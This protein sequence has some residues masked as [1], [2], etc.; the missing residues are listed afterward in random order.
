MP[1]PKPSN[2][3]TAKIVGIIVAVV[4]AGWLGWQ[5]WAIAQNAEA[6]KKMPPAWFREDVDELKDNQKKILAK[7]SLIELWQAVHDTKH[8]KE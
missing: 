6:I 3:W 5:Q 7:L 1:S 2:G 8:E 4:C